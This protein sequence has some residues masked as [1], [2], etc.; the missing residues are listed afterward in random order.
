MIVAT[1]RSSPS[2]LHGAALTAKHF[3][4][5]SK[6]RLTQQSFARFPSFP[7]FDP[8]QAP[9]FLLQVSLQH[10]P[11]GP[12]LPSSQ[13]RL[14]FTTL[15][16]APVVGAS[17]GFKVGAAVVG[18][19]VVGASVGLVVGV[20]VVGADVVGAAVV[21]ASVGARVG[22]KLGASVGLVVGVAVV[23]VAVVGATVGF[24]VGEAVSM[25]LHKFAITPPPCSHLLG[26][27]LEPSS[28]RP[29]AF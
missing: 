6:I 15:V 29:T 28:Q 24:K 3:G 16:G 17:V 20:A 19:P 26:W 18:A 12:I 25:Q 11:L 10:T 5:F 13:N 4:A 7:Q 21:G 23:G 14:I 22:A 9:V 8:P 27:G 2:K 1:A